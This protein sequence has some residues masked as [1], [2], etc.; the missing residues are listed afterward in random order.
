M[1]T[2]ASSSGVKQQI[3]SE[4]IAVDQATPTGEPGSYCLILQDLKVTPEIKTESDSTGTVVGVNACQVCM[5]VQATVAQLCT[6]SLI[7][8]GYFVSLLAL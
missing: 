4:D 2:A 3:D 7:D 1:T 6:R 5:Y 8:C